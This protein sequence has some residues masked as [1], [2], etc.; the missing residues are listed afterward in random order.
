MRSQSSTHACRS[1]PATLAL[2]PLASAA[3]FPARTTRGAIPSTRASCPSRSAAHVRLAPAWLHRSPAQRPLARATEASVCSPQAALRIALPASAS[4]SLPVRPRDRFLVAQ[5]APLIRSSV[6]RTRSE[7]RS[8]PHAELGPSS[9]PSTCR[10]TAPSSTIDSKAPCSFPLCPRPA[11]GCDLVQKKTFFP[12][13]HSRLC[14]PDHAVAESSL[15]GP[16]PACTYAAL[17]LLVN[18]IPELIPIWSLK[19]NVSVLGHTGVASRTVIKI[20]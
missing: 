14:A 15:A 12:A 11:P 8:H 4:H 5:L 1:L 18:S 6:C 20:N 10:R 2:H 19:R 3:C 17:L 13:S 9:R 7:P 16:D